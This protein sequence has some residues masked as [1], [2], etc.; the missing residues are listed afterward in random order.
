MFLPDGVSVQISKMEVIQEKD[1]CDDNDDYQ[2]LILET[3]TATEDF[4]DSFLIIRTD[5]WAIDQNEIDSFCLML[6]TYMKEY[7]E[8]VTL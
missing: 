1:S 7:L 8:K 6:K 4:K 3:D 2:R 5:R